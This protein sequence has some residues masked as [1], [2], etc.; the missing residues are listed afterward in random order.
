MYTWLNYL[1]TS[2][3]DKKDGDSEDEK[4]LENQEIDE[5]EEDEEMDEGT[6]YANGYFDNGEAYAD[7]DNPQDENES[8][9]Y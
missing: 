5:E 9:F 3:E 6:D 4:E 2:A 7:E 1:W 8:T